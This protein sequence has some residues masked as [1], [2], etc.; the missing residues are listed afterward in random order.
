MIKKGS[1]KKA[2]LMLHGRGADADDILSISDLFNATSYAMTAKNNEWYPKPFMK[3]RKENEPRLSESL[4]EIHEAIKEIQ[5]EHK[6]IYILGFSQGACLAL[7]YAAQNEMSGAVGFSGGFIGTE[8]ELP[9]KTKT[10]KIMIG[11]S[12]KD[13]FIPITRAQKTAEIYKEN[14]A[15]VK[16]IFYE[17]ET[18]TITKDEIEI[19]KK[20]LNI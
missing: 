11:C 7:E 16:T 17:G 14:N 20:Q 4:K 15:D 6:E 18:H 12:K 10:K 19:A 2:I 8:E 5:K 9:Q 1:G 3:P 13:P